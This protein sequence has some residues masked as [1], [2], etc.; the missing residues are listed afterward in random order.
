ME[1]ERSKVISESDRHNPEENR[2]IETSLEKMTKEEVLETFRGL[3]ETAD[4]EHDLYLRSMA[5]VENIK[6]RVA[7]EKEE[8]VKYANENLV[9]SILP[10]MD[11]LDKAVTHAR[12]GK[13]LDALREGVELTLKG[14]KDSLG[15]SG[16]QEVEAAGAAFDPH[17]HEAVYEKEDDHAPVG[18]VIQELQ[19]GYTLHG[20]LIRPAMVVVSKGPAKGEK[21]EEIPR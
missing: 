8:W 7:K 3:K 6:K 20:R 18:T 12:D 19:K 15:K 11:N 2:S 4:R 16:V 9:K 21:R 5:E 13:S 14:L 1:E 10:F 17:Y